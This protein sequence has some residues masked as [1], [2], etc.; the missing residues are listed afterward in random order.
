ML[1]CISC[2]INITEWRRSQ[3][4]NATQ[5]FYRGI[6]S[7]NQLMRLQ[8]KGIQINLPVFEILAV[9]HPVST[10]VSAQADVSVAPMRL[11][12]H[13]L[14]S[15]QPR[16]LA[17]SWDCPQTAV[18]ASLSLP[19][20]HHTSP[21]PSSLTIGVWT[22]GLGKWQEESMTLTR[23]S[24]FGTVLRF[25]KTSE[26]I[27]GTNFS[28]PV[29]DLR[30]TMVICVIGHISYSSQHGITCVAGFFYVLSCFLQD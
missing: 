7:M 8:Y 28:L 6:F 14:A 23:Q 1:S 11:V 16:T 13:A 29:I 25:G 12:R 21:C 17:F 19:S 27:F 2:C 20:S 5:N 18:T 3:F 9:M 4:I 15:G 26:P 24:S 30:P 22:S 10:P